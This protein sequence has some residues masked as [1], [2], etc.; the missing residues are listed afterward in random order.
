MDSGAFNT[1]EMQMISIGSVNPLSTVLIYC[2]SG[3]NDGFLDKFSE[4][5][6][7]VAVRL[8]KVLIIGEFNIHVDNAS[9]KFAAE[10]LATTE[11]LNL[12]HHVSGP[13]HNCGQTLDLVFSLGLNVTALY[14]KDVFLSDHNYI[15][16]W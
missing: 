16:L 12:I 14:V 13:T 5:L 9:D 2:P 4:F 6:T 3:P 1:F 15:I 11:S 10:F 7:S 8:D